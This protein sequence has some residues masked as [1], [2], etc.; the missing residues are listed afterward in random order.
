MS[1]AP[2]PALFPAFLRLA[3]RRVLVVGGGKVAE[4]KLRGLIET[5]ARLTV[6][7]PEVRDAIA[8][9]PVQVLR[10]PFRSED[11]DGAWLVVAAAPPDVNREVFAA[12]ETRGVFVNAVDDPVHGSAYTGGV[13]RRGGVTIAVST[14]GRA[15]ALAGLLREALEAVIPEEVAAWVA[16]GAALRREQKQAGVPIGERR[17]L[18]LRA[19][20]R[21]YAGRREVLP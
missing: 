4:A 2:E 21:L 8:S 12:G 18:L 20:N 5:G 14:E 1:G 17:P 11:A 19:L 16:A 6:V 7:A 9:L 3:G 13:L 15:P 10:R